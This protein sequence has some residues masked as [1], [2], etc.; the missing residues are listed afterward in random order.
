MSLDERGAVSR[1]HFLFWDLLGI[2]GFFFTEFP[3]NRR[4]V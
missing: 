2:W 1:R 3:I 4:K